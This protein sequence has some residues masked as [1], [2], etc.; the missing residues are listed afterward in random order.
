MTISDRGRVRIRTLLMI[1]ATIALSL[2]FG[3]WLSTNR[4]TLDIVQPGPSTLPA[5]WAIAIEC[6]TLC[7]IAWVAFAQG[8][9]SQIFTS[10]EC[11][12]FVGGVSMF[13]SGFFRYSSGARGLNWGFY[14]E[15]TAAVGYFTASGVFMVLRA[16]PMLYA[17]IVALTS[18]AEIVVRTSRVTHWLWTLPSIFLAGKACA[19]IGLVL[20][21]RW[22]WP[23]DWSRTIAL[24]W[25]CSLLAAVVLVAVV[26]R[27]GS[28]KLAIVNLTATVSMLPFF[29]PLY[30]DKTAELSLSDLRSIGPSGWL[31]SIGEVFIVV[32]SMALLLRN[33]RVERT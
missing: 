5:A 18:L 10:F 33:S 4:E 9:F 31:F 6:F 15:L 22:N 12:V 7:Q 17:A 27:D 24:A 13:N 23:N 29:V 2:A 19:G 25:E 14:G 16:W 28:R 11:I 26:G 20:D 1:A 8:R 21:P 3:R 30:F 32:G